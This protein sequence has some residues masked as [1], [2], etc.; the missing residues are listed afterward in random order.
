[1]EIHT[2]IRIFSLQSQTANI[3]NQKFTIICITLFLFPVGICFALFQTRILCQR[4]IVFIAPIKTDHC[5]H[6]QWMSSQGH[7]RNGFQPGTCIFKI[8]VCVYCSIT[9]SAIKIQLHNPLVSLQSPIL[10]IYLWIS[11]FC[12]LLTQTSAA[13]FL[14]SHKLVSFWLCSVFWLKVH[15]LYALLIVNPPYCAKKILRAIDIGAVCQKRVFRSCLYW[16]N[17]AHS[18]E[19]SLW[20]NSSYY[21]QFSPGCG[22]WVQQTL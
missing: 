7:H 1:M 22:R 8:S 20:F 10:I 17:C 16:A 6:I 18:P 14:Y 11:I 19:T 4:T 3:E 5:V 13:L 21:S 9:L 15:I 2:N 12:Y